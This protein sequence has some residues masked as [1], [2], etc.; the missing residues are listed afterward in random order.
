MKT[1]YPDFFRITQG[2][3]FASNMN[4]FKKELAKG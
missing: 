4:F 2:L 3:S 1:I